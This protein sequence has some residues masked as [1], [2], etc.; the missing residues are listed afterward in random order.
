[1]NIVDID[2]FLAVVSCGNISKAAEKLYITQPALSLKIGNLEKELSCKLFIRKRGIRNVEL[3]AEGKQFI[4]LADRYKSL[5]NE[6]QKLSHESNTLPFKLSAINSV[7]TIIL[8]QVILNFLHSFPKARLE[9][10][11]LSSMASYDAI[12]SKR[13]DLALIVDTRYSI[14]SLC[15]PL[16]SEKMNFVCNN[17]NHFP[18]NIKVTNLD[19]NK[20]IYSPWF[21][22]F[23]QWHDLKFSR[24]IKPKVQVQTMDHLSFFLQQPNSW[25]IVPATV[26]YNL[27]KYPYIVSH[28]LQAE[29]PDRIIKY[30]IHSDTDAIYTA[31]Y[32]KILKSHLQKMQSLNLLQCLL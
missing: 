5:R 6:M 29:I 9:E 7:N 27:R 28:K 11:D 13:I 25:S 19:Q 3:T 31:P 18:K 15:K 21:L 23:E 22:E 17:N 32:I 30:L 24:N 26:E 20:E 4:Q 1:M 14:K 2:S 12:E 16:F 10:E 8:P